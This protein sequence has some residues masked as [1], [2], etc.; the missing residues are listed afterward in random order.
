[1]SYQVLNV[2]NHYMMSY[3]IF[4]IAVDNYCCYSNMFINRVLKWLQAWEK[5]AV[6]CDT[7]VVNSDM[8][9]SELRFLGSE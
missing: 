9:G 3:L 7:L 4:F 1:M 2:D 8:Q 5:V 6:N